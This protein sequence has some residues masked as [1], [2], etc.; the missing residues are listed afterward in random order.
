MTSAEVKQ[1][2]KEMGMS[3]QETADLL[4]IPKTTYQRYHD[5]SANIPEELALKLRDA[6][7]RMTAWQDDYFKVRLPAQLDSTFPNGI[8]SAGGHE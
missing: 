4:D 5:G 3:L 1:L 2:Q 7:R 8:I 6:H